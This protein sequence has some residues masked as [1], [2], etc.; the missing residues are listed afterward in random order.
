MIPTEQRSAMV[1]KSQMQQVHLSKLQA[2]DR[3]RLRIGRLFVGQ[4]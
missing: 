2:Q 1:L 4:R 3:K